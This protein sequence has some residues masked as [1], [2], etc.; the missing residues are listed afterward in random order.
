MRNEGCPP[1]ELMDELLEYWEDVQRRR[2]DNAYEYKVPEWV[3][4]RAVREHE[5]TGMRFKDYWW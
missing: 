3:M 2:V 1:K 5:R 4:E